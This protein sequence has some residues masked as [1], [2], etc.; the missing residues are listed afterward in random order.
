MLLEIFILI[1]ILGPN[2]VLYYEDCFAVDLINIVSIEN[3]RG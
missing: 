2:T 1:A 3:I